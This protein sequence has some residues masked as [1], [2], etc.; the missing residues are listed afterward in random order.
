MKKIKKLF[1][2]PIIFLRDYLNKKYPE[3]NNEQ[4]CK[5]VDEH[6]LIKNDLSLCSIGITNSPK[7]IDVVFTWVDSTDKT[8]QKQR[9]YY[10]KQFGQPLGLFANDTARFENHNELKYAVKSVKYYL[11]WVRNIFLVTDNQTPDCL[12]DVIMVKHSDIIDKKHLP[13]FNSHVIEAHLHKIPNLSEN[14]IYFND[15]V[16]VAR[17]LPPSHFF[18]ENDIAS[19]FVSCK[20]IIKM[21]QKNVLTPTL[22][23]TLNSNELLQ[24]IYKTNIDNPLIHTYMPLKK[25]FFDLAW[26]LFH[27][28]IQS[29]LSNRF[30]M[31]NDLNLATFLVPWLMYLNG[32][33]VFRREICYYFN[34]RSPHATA[35]YKKLLQKK[36]IQQEPHSFCAN[37]F[38][39]SIKSVNYEIQLQQFLKQYFTI[40]DKH[41]I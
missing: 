12:Q 10:S 24:K 5:S 26:E 29:F 21:R 20:S 6:I 31:D 18:Q 7:D 36:K 4:N 32:K 13:T 17:K 25:S 30:R 34:I 23:A 35:Q 16:F 8:W 38:N 15:D 2:H 41:V 1:K 40:K 14:F 11:P 28:E 33:S 9:E 3:I 39:S 22:M 37:D 19:I 27:D